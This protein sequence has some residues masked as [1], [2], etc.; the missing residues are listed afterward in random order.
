MQCILPKAEYEKLQHAKGLGRF[1]K[2][3]SDKT[4]KAED[5]KSKINLKEHLKELKEEESKRVEDVVNT[6]NLFGS[7]K[8]DTIDQINAAAQKKAQKRISL[9]D[10]GQMQLS[11]ASAT[12]KS[13]K[14][15][16]HKSE[17]K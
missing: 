14:K 1:F 13:Q 17:E 9:M 7:R 4:E 5:A 16:E 6:A 15:E 12:P 10:K 2:A 3:A 8:K 11:F